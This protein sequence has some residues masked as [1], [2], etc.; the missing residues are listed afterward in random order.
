MKQW[1]YITKGQVK[2]LQIIYSSIGHTVEEIS[3]DM[4]KVLNLYEDKLKDGSFKA[5]TKY[6]FI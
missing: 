6:T 4:K 3:S 1:H 5:N 2:G